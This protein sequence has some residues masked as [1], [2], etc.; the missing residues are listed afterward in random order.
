MSEE[1]YFAGE[2]TDDFLNAQA[3]AGEFHL[4]EMGFFHMPSLGEM[5][6]L[7]REGE[8]ILAKRGI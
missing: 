8:V 5:R 7:A 2:F 1:E 6:A 4:D 3:D